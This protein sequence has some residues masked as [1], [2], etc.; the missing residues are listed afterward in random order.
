M[1]EDMSEHKALPTQNTSDRPAAWRERIKAD[2]AAQV[3][4][5]GTLYGHCEGGVRNVRITDP[6]QIARRISPE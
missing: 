6:D 3:E 2:L 4:A 1:V 5:G